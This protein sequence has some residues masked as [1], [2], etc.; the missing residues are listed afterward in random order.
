M[1][2]AELHAH[3]NFS[4]LDGASHPAELVHEALR[5]GLTGL[6]IT[7]HDGLYG[8]VRL[9]EAA[10]GTGLLTVF[11]T[12]ISLGRGSAR[13]GTPDPGGEHLVVLA[14]DPR[15]YAL[16][17]QA[18]AE[19]HLDGGLKG[20]PTFSLEKLAGWHQGHWTVLTGCRRGPLATALTVEG[21]SGAARALDRL[22]EVFGRDRVVVELWDHGEPIDTARNDALALLAVERGVDPVATNN[23][24][25]ATPAGFPL[26][27][28]LAAIRAGRPLATLDGWLP[29]SSSACLR[30]PHEQAR[31]F[32]R[33]PGA[34]ERTVDIATDC[35]FD[36][37][38]V[39]PRLPDF[40]VPEGHDEQSWLAELVRQGALERYGPRH[41]ERIP[42]AWSRI[43]HEL[44]VIAALGFPGYFLTV[45]D[46]VTFCRRQDIFCQGRG[47][48]ATSAVCYA[49]GITNVDAVALG[50]L[51]E[52]FLS[53]ARDGPPDIDVDI[54]SGRR[55]EVIR[56]VYERY[57]RLHAAQVANVITYRTRSALR[58]V[59]A[60]LGYGR[61][62]VRSWSAAVD[63]THPVGEAGLPDLA[64]HLVGQ[65][66]HT[67]RHLGIHSGGMVIC[68]RP[69]VEVCPVEWAR[70]PG[71]TVV[72]WDKDDC[73]AVGL[74]KFDLLGLGMLGALHHMVDLVREH[75]GVEVDLARLPQETAVYDLL[76]DA[77]TV[78]VFQVESR[79]QMGTLP[80]V[81]P[82]CFYD[83]AIEVAL[84]RPGPIQGRAVHPYIRR[85]NGEEPVTNLHPLL[86]PAL[87]RT[88]GV[89]LFQEQL[90]QIAIDVAGFSPVEADELRQAMSAKRSAERMA[91]LR[92]RLFAGMADRGVPE[93]IAG[94]VFTALAAFADFGFP[95]SHSI[96]F[97]H[98]V[99]ATAWFKVH[100]PAAF[101]AGLLNAQPM[102]FWSPQSLVADAGRHGVATLRP[103]VQKSRP[104]CSI[105]DPGPSIR[106]G[107]TSV[108]GIGRET[109]ER[110]T[111]GAPWE[112]LEDLVRRAGVGRGQL[113]SLAAA[114]A[115]SGLTAGGRRAGGRREL[116][117]AAGAAAQATPDRLPGVVTGAEAPPLAPPTPADDVADDLWT[118]GLA[119]ETTAMALL[120]PELRARGVIEARML[121]DAASGERVV[122][123]GVV[124][125]RQQPES[126]H[127]AVFLN[128][129][130]ETGMVNAICSPGAWLRWQRIAR[131]APALLVRGRVDR[132]Q[133]AVT[134]VVERNEPLHVVAAPPA[135]NFR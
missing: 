51:F 79:A 43:D 1:A 33:W 77:D 70:M 34:V 102:G 21:P 68:D 20:T 41:T 112:S 23:V 103:H 84:I 111:A 104:A 74:V 125:H 118:L 132:A 106:L 75:Q 6:G 30:G 7:D 40:P 123:G 73:A 94:Q 38:L 54:E 17:S 98:L 66:L 101:T 8:V 127:G 108:R 53:P 69:V 29:A 135:R 46:I 49:L 44:E 92:D 82:R 26:A 90:M 47:S 85:R 55:E 100:H 22:I 48:A 88:L 122:V 133:R 128:L 19:A 109:A 64:R 117:W 12:E 130:D 15:G 105:E 35:A 131:S 129:E 32:A 59:G 57:G 87:R 18:V 115:L 60:A 120:R 107:L 28:T 83:L 3:S 5:L 121:A 2:Y 13:T 134:L 61:E 4:F 67:P 10:R 89:P 72:Q 16:L 14:R 86:E 24:H 56:Y 50:L 76:C 81:R 52:R 95:E 78:G 42:G 27:T 63:R 99:Y 93:E 114:G 65:I 62:T 36:L 9:A 116:I 71:R 25:Y 97:A 124:T 91:R 96:A 80:R 11:G 113:E 110:I 45:W 39:A 58:D 119:P 37:R 31:R 126:A